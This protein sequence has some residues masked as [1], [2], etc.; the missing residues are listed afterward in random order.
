MSLAEIR[1]KVPNPVFH[2]NLPL[3]ILLEKKPRPD[4]PDWVEVGCW[5]QNEV[6]GMV[7]YLS[8]IDAM[9]DLYERNREGH[10]YQI[11]PFESIDPRPFIKE[12]NGWLTVYLAYGFAASSNGLLL[13]SRGNPITLPE[14]IHFQIDPS[15]EHFHLQFGGRILAWLE[16]LHQKAGLPDYNRMAQ[17]NAHTFPDE[18]DRLAQEALS[19]IKSHQGIKRE[20]S[21]CALY[22]PIEQKWH[23]VDF[24][25]LHIEQ[26]Q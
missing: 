11:F 4:A 8:P 5:K 18:L 6:E 23:L 9:I 25:S 19:H 13:N 17:E 2:C 3:Y 20:C 15:N 21:H 14:G 26:T 7:A 1:L 10:Q 12:H 16:R 22:D 24:D